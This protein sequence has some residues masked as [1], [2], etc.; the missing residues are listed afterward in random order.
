MNMFNYHYNRILMVAL[1]VLVSVSTFA[2]PITREQA[3]QR[4]ESYLSSLPNRHQA[5]RLTPVQN[6]AKL[7]PRRSGVS[8]QPAQDLS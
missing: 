4:A 8:A 1:A 5:P 7:A 2:D 6:R 3:Q